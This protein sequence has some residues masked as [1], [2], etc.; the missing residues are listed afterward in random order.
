MR[1]QK[2]HTNNMEMILRRSHPS[3]I[4]INCSLTQVFKTDLQKVVETSSVLQDGN[5]TIIIEA[6]R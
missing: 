6:E 1:K 5:H 2:Y 3:I 4:G